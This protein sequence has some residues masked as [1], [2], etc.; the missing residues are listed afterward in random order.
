ML[1]K[2]FLLTAFF[3]LNLTYCNSTRYITGAG[4]CDCT[5][6]NEQETC[7]PR[8]PPITGQYQIEKIINYK[9]ED[10]RAPWKPHPITINFTSKNFYK[11]RLLSQKNYLSNKSNIYK[12]QI[13]D[14][15]GNLITTGRLVE[16]TRL[17]TPIRL[18]YTKKDFYNIKSEQT[19]YDRRICTQKRKYKKLTEKDDKEDL[20]L[21]SEQ[22]LLEYRGHC[23]KF[24]TV[25]MQDGNLVTLCRIFFNRQEFSKKN[26]LEIKPCEFYS[27]IGSVLIED[28]DQNLKEVEINSQVK[29]FDSPYVFLR[30]EQL[31][32]VSDELHIPDGE[33]I[34]EVVRMRAVCKPKQEV[35]DLIENF[36]K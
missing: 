19:G 21:C 34:V 18:D 1:S 23:L 36:F 25:E 12:T 3:L 8:D 7:I 35:S 6:Q 22:I 9:A 24:E 33:K 16:A 17:S 29:N 5:S 26:R 31:R 27:F 20:E 30:A 11:R 15:E 2:T 10:W 32:K 4:I 13:L 28:E 14:K